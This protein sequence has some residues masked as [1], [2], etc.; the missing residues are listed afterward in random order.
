MLVLQRAKS[1]KSSGP[2]CPWNVPLHLTWF[3]K[4]QTFFDVYIYLLRF[5]LVTCLKT[6][7]N[8]QKHAHFR[9]CNTICDRTWENLVYGINAQFVQ[10][11]FLVPQ[12]L[13]VPQVKNYESPNF[14]ISMSKNP[15]SN[16]SH[17]LRRIAVSYKG[18]ISLHFD[19]PS[20]Y[21]C[22][23]Q[24]PLLRVIIRIRTRR[25]SRYS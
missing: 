23:T 4:P 22:R 7:A 1:I 10:C 6:G 2:F 21:S 9:V 15:S 20:L 19:L 8:F 16:C 17:R 13:L 5:T 24:S 14:V 25:L 11:W 18:E 3:L 12:G